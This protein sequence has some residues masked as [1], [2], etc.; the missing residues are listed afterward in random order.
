MA[1]V[2]CRIIFIILFK[3]WLCL[4]N[5][6]PDQSLFFIFSEPLKKE[7]HVV[8]IMM[9]TSLKLYLVGIS[10]IIWPQFLLLLINANSNIH[11]TINK[12]IIFFLFLPLEL[13]SDSS[14]WTSDHYVC[15]VSSGNIY[16][17]D[18]QTQI[19][20]LSVGLKCRR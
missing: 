16:T 9:V 18:S 8:P 2:L 7:F 11:M 1:W 13:Q 10:D 20:L 12:A 3:H 15:S 19:L 4:I 5:S 17:Q 14:S 6:G